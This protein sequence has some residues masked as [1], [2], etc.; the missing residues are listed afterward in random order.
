MRK[1]LLLALALSAVSLYYYLQVLKQVYVVPPAAGWAPL[2]IPAV[3][4]V[5]LA[6]LAAGVLLLGC[7]PQLLLGPLT[8]AVLAAGFAL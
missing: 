1:A 7:F 6:L 4:Q 3:T 5:A 2:R 8:S